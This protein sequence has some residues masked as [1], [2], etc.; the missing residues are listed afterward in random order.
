MCSK[1]IK[2]KCKEQLKLCLIYI[3]EVKTG[4]ILLLEDSIRQ[5]ILIK[6]NNTGFTQS[7]VGFKF[8]NKEETEKNEIILQNYEKMLREMN[9]N[10]ELAPR[11]TI[12][13]SELS[14]K[15]AI[16]IAN[17][18]KISHS[19]LGKTNKRLFSLCVRCEFLAERMKIKD[20]EWY[21][22]FREL[23][24][25]IEATLDQRDANLED[26]KKHIKEKY[27]SQFSELES[28]F[29]KKNNKEFI[30]FILENYPYKDYQEDKK[31]KRIDTSKINQELIQYL[32]GKYHSPQYFYEEEISLF[33]YCIEEIIESYLNYLYKNIQ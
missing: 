33:I 14:L 28:K 7:A 18:V 31:N 6:S 25:D 26:M 27:K 2:E 32:I 30:D 13:S 17:I 16:C 8:S 21:K 11:K 24:K 22:E 1:E 4:S 5:G 29:N 20:K 23:Y 9:P 10:I 3:N 19:F 12:S 15:E